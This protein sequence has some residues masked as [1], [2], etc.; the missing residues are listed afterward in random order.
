MGNYS[1]KPLIED[2]TWS[3]SRVS[4]F[5]SCPNAWFLKYIKGKQEHG[6]FYSSFGKLVHNIIE[7][8]YRGEIEKDAMLMEFLTRFSNEVVGEKPDEKIV[9]GYI[10]G[11]A[12]YFSEFHPLPYKMI[13][14]EKSISFTIGDKKFVGIIDYI[15]LDG[16]DICIV[17]NKSGNLKPR[18]KRKY[19]T[20][21]DMELDIKLRQLYIY[22][23][24]IKNEYG[25]YPA[26]LCFNCYRTG[27]LIEEPFIMS[28]YENA[29][30]WALGEISKIEDEK[31]FIADPDYFRCRWLCGYNT[32]CEEYEEYLKDRR[33]R[34]R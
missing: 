27:V 33:H 13:D 1:Y 7:R 4:S 34:R 22:S 5:D 10:N 6:M 28:E 24:A 18:S 20:Q 25:K 21:K 31:Y 2:M 15:G 32:S 17:D 29:I 23:E 16:D 12:S 3:Y 9:N 11:A 8:Y 26:K 19:P 30:A 14:V